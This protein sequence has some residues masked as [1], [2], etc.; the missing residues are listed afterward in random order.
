MKVEHEYKSSAAFVPNPEKAENA[1]LGCC[2]VILAFGTHCQPLEY[3]L[4]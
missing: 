2:S 3:F 1:V 4:K